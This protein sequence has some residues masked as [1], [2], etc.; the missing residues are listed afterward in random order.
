MNS[1]NADEN[2]GQIYTIYHVLSLCCRNGL[3]PAKHRDISKVFNLTN[4]AVKN[5]AMLFKYIGSN[6]RPEGM[7]NTRAN[8]FQTQVLDDD[9]S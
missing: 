2:E 5:Q 1:K 9:A 8:V 3:R 6:S 7:A 4:D